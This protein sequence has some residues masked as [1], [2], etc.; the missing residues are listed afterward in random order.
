ML[1]N[2]VL[3]FFRSLLCLLGVL[4]LELER[5]TLNLDA[6][7]LN[8]WLSILELFRSKLYLD[9]GECNSWLSLE[10]GVLR[11]TLYREFGVCNS[12]LSWEFKSALNLLVGMLSSELKREF[13]EE[14]EVTELPRFTRVFLSL[15]PGNVKY[16][17]QR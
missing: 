7:L 17:D 2:V 3:C 15:L 16:G 11:S 13:K 14:F 4:D 8:S 9:L 1:S 12:R 10:W 6:E 5:S